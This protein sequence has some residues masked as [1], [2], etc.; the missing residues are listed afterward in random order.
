M[1]W[2][3]HERFSDAGLPLDERPLLHLIPHQLPLHNL[4]RPVV[5]LA[6]H[7]HQVVVI[8]QAAVVELPLERA[9]CPAPRGQEY[10]RRL[11]RVERRVRALGRARAGRV[12]DRAGRVADV[13]RPAVDTTIEF[14]QR[15]GRAWVGRPDGRTLTYSW[16]V[17]QS[18]NGISDEGRGERGVLLPS[19]R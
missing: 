8:P 17:G 3:T 1:D 11:G 18:M 2:F 5:V 19:D 16:E 15:A 14:G 13:E 7:R 10:E 12:G 9:Q 6:R 4:V